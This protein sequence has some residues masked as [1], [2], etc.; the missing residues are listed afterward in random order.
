MTKKTVRRWAVEQKTTLSRGYAW[1]STPMMGIILISSVKMV[2]PG[3]IDS[4][5]KFIG[6]NILGLIIIYIIG[7]IDKRLRFFHEE[8]DYIIDSNPHLKD[9]IQGEKSDR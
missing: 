3:L 4:T 7:Y 1:A 2:F 8:N 6:L 5:L 9:L